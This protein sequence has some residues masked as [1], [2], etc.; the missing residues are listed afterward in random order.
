MG[1]IILTYELIMASGRDAGNVSMR[2][3]GRTAWNIDDWNAAT[4][5]V[6][7]LWPYLAARGDKK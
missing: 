1:A 2:K 3:A 4:E 7:K 5:V 6:E